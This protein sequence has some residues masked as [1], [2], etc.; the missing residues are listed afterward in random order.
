MVQQQAMKEEI[1][2]RAKKR[3][4]QIKRSDQLLKKGKENCLRFLRK[5]E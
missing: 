3:T 1:E 5:H 2:N 4:G